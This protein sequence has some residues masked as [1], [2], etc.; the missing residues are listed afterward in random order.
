LNREASYAAVWQMLWTELAKE[1]RELAGRPYDSSLTCH[2]R[3]RLPRGVVE[4]VFRFVRE[5]GLEAGRGYERWCGKRL[6][7]L[8]G[9]TTRTER[10]EELERRYGLPGGK[11]SNSYF[12]VMRWVS[13][14]VAGTAVVVDYKSGPYRRSELALAKGLL[15]HLRE[16]DLLLA[17]EYYASKH[18]QAKLASRGVEY[19]M[20]L[21]QRF[22]IEGHPH[23]RIG[24]GDYLVTIQFRPTERRGDTQVPEKLHARVIYGPRKR[25]GTKRGVAVITSLVDSELYPAKKVLSCY[26]RRWGFETH[27]GE[28]KTCLHTQRFRSKTAAGVEKELCAHLVAYNL[29]RVLILKAGKRHRVNPRRISFISAVRKVLE[30]SKAM[31]YAP[32]GRLFVMYDNLLASI[33]ADVNPRRGGRREPRALRDAYKRYAAF[34]SSRSEWRRTGALQC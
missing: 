28:V 31:R 4:E 1:F 34:R 33:A 17:D 18:M 11:E 20:R 26:R 7:I 9:S 3:Q 5:K 32:A 13:L 24:E 10:T 25:K 19:I 23:T 27:A 29:V 12:P 14:I 15:E 6:L 21:H 2:A 22:K 30:F 8:D 16:G